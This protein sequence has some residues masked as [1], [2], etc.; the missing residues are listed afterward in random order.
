MP[1]P[2]R[3]VM[4]EQH[5][6]LHTCQ[7]S[8]SP[9]M[10]CTSTMCTLLHTSA[11][12]PAHPPMLRTPCNACV[13]CS[14]FLI[15]RTAE[16]MLMGD[17]ESCNLSE[18]PWNTAHGRCMAGVWPCQRLPRR[19]LEVEPCGVRVCPLLP[20]SAAW[21]WGGAGCIGWEHTG[22]ASFPR[23]SHAGLQFV[24]LLKALRRRQDPSKVPPPAFEQLL[25]HMQLCDNKLGHKPH[26]WHETAR[27]MLQDW[28]DGR[29]VLPRG[30]GCHVREQ[31]YRL[32]GHACC[33]R[34]R[35]CCARG[36]ACCARGRACCARE[37]TCTPAL[38]CWR[39]AHN[40]RGT[41]TRTAP[42]CAHCHRH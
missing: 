3:P 36:R 26:C 12:C 17:L 37:S 23:Q 31:V 8:A 25:K 10:P 2:V 40:R 39:R 9:A 24:F 30:H 34:G 20:W 7:C 21:A 5:C 15:A 42:S 35:A 29:Q 38:G 11:Q 22:M 14:R 13:A 27:P 18:I 32:K 6:T 28:H 16:T 19:R 33:A 1:C 4:K 41:R